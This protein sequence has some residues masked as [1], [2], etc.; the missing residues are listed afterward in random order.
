MCRGSRRSRGH[1]MRVVLALHMF[2]GSHLGAC[3]RGKGIVA[4]L[5]GGA[6]WAVCRRARCCAAQCAG[7]RDAKDVGT[8]YGTGLMG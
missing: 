5:D 2:G 1:W 8:G 3:T 4:P 6:S 7:L